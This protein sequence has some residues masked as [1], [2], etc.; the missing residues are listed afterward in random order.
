[1]P[2]PTVIRNLAIDDDQSL[3]RGIVGHQDLLERQLL[4]VVD[5]RDVGR[6]G[7]Q[8]VG[9][10][11]P[12]QLG[13]PDVK[14]DVGGPVV[15]PTIWLFVTV[16]AHLVLH[17]ALQEPAVNSDRI[18]PPAGGSDTGKTAPPVIDVEAVLPQLQCVLGV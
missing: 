2:G 8:M 3:A 10:E 6:E 9:L 7:A 13:W 15:C 12:R 4:T 5:P 1:M 11:K 18:P 17:R 16:L 14:P